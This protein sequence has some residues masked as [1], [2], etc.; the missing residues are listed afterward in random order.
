[1]ITAEVT[2]E[3][4]KNYTKPPKDA[5]ELNI[6]YFI[7]LLR[8]MHRLKA[9]DMEIV[10]EDLEDY[11]PFK[12]FLIRGL[13]AILEFDK[14]VGFVFADHI[15]FFNKEDQNINVNFK[16]APKRGWLDRLFG[17]NKDDD[18][19]ELEKEFGDMDMEDM[20]MD[21]D[22]N[23]DIDMDFD[24][25]SKRDHQAKPSKEKGRDGNKETLKSGSGRANQPDLV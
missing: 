19:D 14:E 11:N 18:W 9:D 21:M 24:P 22:M 25:D 2:K 5:T 16:P 10:V 15:L 4:Y 20:E 12:R 3:I 8:P 13:T 17:K 7:E 6:P 23:P 1:M